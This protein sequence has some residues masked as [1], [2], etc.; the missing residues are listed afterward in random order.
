MR[1]TLLFCAL[2]FASLGM[3]HGFAYDHASVGGPRRVVAYF[4]GWTTARVADIPA[5]SLTHVIYAFAQIIDGRCALRDAEPDARYSEHFRQL[6]L[7]KREHPHLGT[8]VSVGGWN[9]SAPFS[10]A[11]LTDASRQ[12][13]ARSCAEFVA[14]YGFDGID[15]D[16][17]YPA[18][19]GKD[20]D[21]ARPEDTRNFTL[22]LK[23]LRHQLDE[24]GT[25]DGKTYLLT[26]AT[27]AGP[28]Q[29]RLMQL[30]QVHAYVDWINLM[31]YD[32]TGNWSRK[33]G[34]NAPLFAPT[35][36][37]ATTTQPANR[38]SVDDAVRAYLA[39]GVPP[40]K[41]VVGV[42]FFGHGFGGVPDVNH[43]LFQPHDHKTPRPAND[44]DGWSYR[45]LAAK[46]IDKSAGRFWHDGA[47]VPWL[48]DPASG[49]M[50][51]YD[52]PQSLRLKAEYVRAHNLGG[53]MIWELSQDDDRHS[54][55]NAL[56]DGLGEP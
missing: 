39:A 41:L 25:T 55:L 37:D 20:P 3:A 36:D 1:T 4:A 14:R 42:P 10:D 49:I 17:E 51:T 22:L 35:D 33:T 50:I 53:V 8:L 16:W 52:D 48:Y 29:Y 34:F 27:P 30:D 12:K 23:A 31:T 7:L 15:I 32:L 19:G 43:G 56:R 38:L 18:G 40:E 47:K 44:S 45:A 28:G 6:Q 5:D 9:D 2:A 21:K 26:I 13:F 46:Y 11:A 54:L 24:Q